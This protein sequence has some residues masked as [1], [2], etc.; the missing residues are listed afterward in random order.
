[1][2]GAKLAVTQ[3]QFAVRTQAGIEDLNM[4]WTIHRLDRVIAI[5]R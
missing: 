5:F 2:A 3:R 1:M 4:A